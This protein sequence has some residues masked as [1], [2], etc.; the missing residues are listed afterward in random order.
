MPSDLLKVK[1]E[2]M[3]KLESFVPSVATPRKLRQESS[4]EFLS[5]NFKTQCLYAG[6]IQEKTITYT[7]ADSETLPDVTKCWFRIAQSVV[8]HRS[9][10]NPCSKNQQLGYNKRTRRKPNSPNPSY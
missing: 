10:S 5:E 7:Q 3:T 6:N 8:M 2:A 4:S 9:C 1:S